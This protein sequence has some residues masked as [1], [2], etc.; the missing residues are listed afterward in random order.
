MQQAQPTDPS[1]Q[2]RRE[3]STDDQGEAPGSEHEDTFVDESATPE[4][5]TGSEPEIPE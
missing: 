4:H 3:P 2:E 1:D 5:G